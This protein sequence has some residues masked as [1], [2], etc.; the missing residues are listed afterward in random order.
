MVEWSGTGHDRRH[1]L[2]PAVLA[3]R[4]M[5]IRHR[6]CRGVRILLLLLR[7][8]PLVHA[9][10]KG[11]ARRKTMVVPQAQRSPL[12]ASPLHAQKFQCGPAARGFLPR[13]AD[14]ARQDPFRASDGPLSAEYPATG[15][16]CDSLESG[17]RMLEFSGEGG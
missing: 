5:G 9:L 14:A 7:I 8:H 13:H 4:T 6:R 10:A 16:I 17:K 2:R 1:S 15:L 12:A 3:Q 11:T